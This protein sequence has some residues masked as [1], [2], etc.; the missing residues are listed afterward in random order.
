MQQQ[1]V[2]FRT[3]K[4]AQFTGAI[5]QNNFEDENVAAKTSQ[6]KIRSITII[7]D[8]NLAW[9]LA[10]FTNDTFRN[11]DLDLNTYLGSIR[12]ST[13][14]GL[15]VSGVGPYYYDVSG[16]DIDYIDLDNSD[17]FHLSLINRS[18]TSKNAG[19]TGEIVVIIAHEPVY[20]A[21]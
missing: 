2:I 4:D 19:A 5:T 10:F 8:Q 17:E 13:Q 15:Q 11:N 14:D 6:T 12:F 21:P 1:T 18:A 7:S 9:E 20:V 3:D 16:L